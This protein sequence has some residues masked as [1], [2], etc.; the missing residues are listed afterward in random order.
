MQEALYNEETLIRIEDDRVS[1]YRTYPTDNVK[2]TLREISVQRGFS[3]PKD[4]DTQPFGA[5]LISHFGGKREA[6]V[7]SYLI[8]QIE[9]GTIKLYRICDEVRNVLLRIAEELAVDTK[10]S[11]VE[12]AENVIQE[13]NRVPE[14]VSAAPVSL[15]QATHPLLQTLLTDIQGYF[16]TVRTFSFYN[17]ASLQLNISNYLLNTKHYEEVEV[18][19]LIVAP[20]EIDWLK[21]KRCFIDIVVKD[22]QGWYALLELKYPLYIPDG[23]INSRLGRRLENDIQS[24][25]YSVNQGAQD[26]VRYLFWKD[27]KRIECFC[28]YSEYAVGGIALLLTDDPI[29]WTTPKDNQ[30]TPTLYR[31]FSL[32]PGQPNLL[33]TSRRWREP[34]DSERHY[35]DYPGFD[36]KQIYPLYWGT[37]LAPIKVPEKNDLIFQPCFIVVEK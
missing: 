28:S 37:P 1:V 27:V 12:I 7:G 25:S 15:P 24:E 17:E 5:K 31:E 30:K 3:D 21:S 14:K 9:T 19:Y 34:N 32:R 16:N 23:L 22:S 26:I 33:D 2:A 18:E 11:L 35:K 29:N 13:V 6:L 4:W 10:G 36:L 8:Q 20:D